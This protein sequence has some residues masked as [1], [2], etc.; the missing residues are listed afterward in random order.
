M[1]ERELQ[2]L[3]LHTHRSLKGRDYSSARK[4]LTQAKL[5]L[6]SLNAL[7][8]SSDAPPSTLRLA[9]ETLELAA[10]ISIREQD[11]EGFTRYFSQL[12]PFYDLPAVQ[13]SPD[14]S[15]RS[16]ITGLYLLLLLSQGDYAGFH[17]VLESLELAVGSSKNMQA[18]PN[19]APRIEEDTF[20]Q[21]PIKLERWLMEGS[22]D[23]VWNATKSEKVPSEEYGIFSD[24]RPARSSPS[25]LNLLYRLTDLVLTI[26]LASL[27][28]GRNHSLRDRLLQRKGIHVAANHKC[29]ESLVPRK[30]GER[31]RVCPESRLAHPRRTDILSIPATSRRRHRQGDSAR[32]RS[33]H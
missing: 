16:K 9:R 14:G 21:Y 29:Q 25:G 8:P 6:L 4:Y 19:G 12:Q 30:R 15:N 2:S 10:L 20:I 31:N 5:V 26:V 24:V 33:S 13:L 18:A 27:G 3:L 1:S 32:Q 23:R 11:Y 7:V 28:F 22:Y 17:T